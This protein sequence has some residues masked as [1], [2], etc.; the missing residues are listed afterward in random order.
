MFSIKPVHIMHY[1]EV[2]VIACKVVTSYYLLFLIIHYI[3][4][5]TAMNMQGL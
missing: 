5:T 4:K 1:I 2:P 3:Y